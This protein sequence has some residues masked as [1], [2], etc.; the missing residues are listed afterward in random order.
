[1]SGVDLRVFA[2]YA[3]DF[4]EEVDVAVVGSGPGG[5][6]AAAEL[7]AAGKR[8]VLVEEG[9]PFTP[10][11]YEWEGGLSMARTMR[12]GGLRATVGTADRW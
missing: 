7:T 9:P 2:D 4:T 11:D 8:V 3:R 6:V 1:V 5:A 10:Q 12:E